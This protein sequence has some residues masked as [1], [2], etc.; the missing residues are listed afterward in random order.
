MFNDNIYSPL[1][2]EVLKDSQDSIIFIAMICPSSVDVNTVNF[3][4]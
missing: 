4:S 3:F 2:A 1:T